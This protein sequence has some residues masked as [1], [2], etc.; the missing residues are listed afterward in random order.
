VRNKTALGKRPEQFIHL[1]CLILILAS[2]VDPV[3][4]LIGLL[5]DPAGKHQV[6]LGRTRG[7]N[8]KIYAAGHAY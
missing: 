5:G 6:P 2:Q 1:A 8:I 3:P 7:L 4:R